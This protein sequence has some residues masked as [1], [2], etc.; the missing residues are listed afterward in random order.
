MPIS[1][2]GKKI[3]EGKDTNETLGRRNMCKEEGRKF[4]WV[5]EEL[6]RRAGSKGN[7]IPSY[8]DRAMQDL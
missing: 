6:E 2:V 5:A 8:K 1:G 3:K 4:C 7:I